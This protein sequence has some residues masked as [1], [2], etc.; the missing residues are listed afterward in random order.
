MWYLPKLGDRM[1]KRLTK[2]VVEAIK[3][4]AGRDVIEWDSELHGFGV[5]VWSRRRT[6]FVKYRTKEGRQ[7]RATIGV[8]GI[9]TAEQARDEARH[10]LA[11]A[12][13]GEDPARSKRKAKGA[14]TVA[15]LAER[16]LA[17]HARLHKTPSSLAN[18]ERLLKKRIIPALGH[19]KVFDIAR[20]D[21]AKLHESLCDKR[22]EA[23]RLR[24]LLSTMFNLAEEWDLRP[25]RTNPCRHVKK[26]VEKKRKRFLRMDELARL[27]TAIEEADRTAAHSTSVIGAIKL[28]L[29]TGCRLSE[30]L[31]LQW[32]EV[33]LESG[34][35]D[36]STS[37]TGQKVVHLNAA[38]RA[39]LEQLPRRDDNRYV[40]P[41]LRLG[42]HLV[43][44]EKPWRQIRARAG[45]EDVRLHDLRHTFA[46]IGAMNGLSL[47]MLAAILG[48]SQPSTTN[49]YAHLAADPVRQ[50]NEIVGAVLEAGIRGVTGQAG[51]RRLP[52]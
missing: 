42:A 1:S 51:P 31:T 2:R 26:Y 10:L 20:E 43:N 52:D 30:I 22:C 14:P 44:L 47:P 17:E 21:V 35:L 50:A 25:P 41:G 46:S 11:Q 29:F 4:V 8:H 27:G 36:L 28:L 45:L 19:R 24:A 32:S 5:R 34:C 48:H 12:A 39:V 37:K 38:A 7:R 33:D 49:R 3:P 15:A 23:N 40:L 6:Y 13:L 16:Y 9:L 18:D